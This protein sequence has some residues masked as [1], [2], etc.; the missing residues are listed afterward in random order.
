MLASSAG[1]SDF[2]LALLELGGAD[3]VVRNAARGCLDL[4]SDSDD[5]AFWYFFPVGPADGSARRYV[6]RDEFPADI[7][8]A[9]DDGTGEAY[10]TFFNSGTAYACAES[11]QAV[12]A[13]ALLL[14][15][16]QTTSVSD[17]LSTMRSWG[18]EAPDGSWTNTPVDSWWPL[19]G[20]WK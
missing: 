2:M 3:D 6:T 12:E 10:Y 9:M 17:A 19:L 13:F 1:Q 5:P 15:G 11:V 4:A 16:T 20:V 8:Q 14:R 18:V 7:A